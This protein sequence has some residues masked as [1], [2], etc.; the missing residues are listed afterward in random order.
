MRIFRRESSEQGAV[1]VFLIMIFA[2]VF[3]F[4]AVF[5]DF[6]RMSA[7]HAQAESLSRAAVRS[8]LSAYDPI[9]LEQYGL[10]AYGTT[11]ENYIMSKVLQERLSLLP[12]SDDLPIMSTALDSSTVEMLRP[13]GQYSIFNQQIREQMKYKAPIDFSLEIMNQF[14]PISQMMKEASNTMDVM[15]KLQPLYEERERTLD[16][17]LANQKEAAS[18]AEIFP[19]LIKGT[20]TSE[21]INDE[22]LGGEVA[23]A[24]DVAAQYQDYVF[25]LAED[26]ERVANKEK[27]IYSTEIRNY[28]NEA[29]D[30]LLGIA[31][32]NNEVA[33][34]HRDLLPEAS[35]LVAEA[36]Q[37][38]EQMKRVIEDS[39]N[40]V[41]GEVYNLNGSENSTENSQKIQKIRKQSRSLLLPDGL[42]EQFEE[43]VHQQERDFNQL[44][45]AVSGLSIVQSYI[46]AASG[47]DTNS[48]K[49]KITAAN[50]EVNVYLNKYVWSGNNVLA[51]QQKKLDAYRTYDEERKN[52]EKE[53]KGKLSEV[54]S[55]LTKI[56]KLKEKLSANQEQF[57]IL[58]GYYNDNVKFNEQSSEE[59]KRT[60]HMKN[61]PYEAGQGSMKEM[62]DLYGELSQIM[63]SLS[64]ACY[65]TEYGINYYKHFEMG[66]LKNLLTGGGP[67]FDTVSDQ[68]TVANQEVEYLLYGFH[69]TVGNIA[70]AYGEIFAMRLAIRTMEGFVENANKGHPLLILA[71]ALL[72]GVTKALV[73]M[74]DLITK[75][76]LEFSKYVK[77]RLSYRDHLRVFLLVHGTS[78]HRLSRMLALI[79][80][81]T[82]INVEERQ[83]YISGE[84]TLTIPL[85]FLPGLARAS[86]SL[87]SW[88]GRVEGSRYYAIKRA[89][90]SY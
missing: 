50:M 40:R 61:N 3:T 11:D 56:N 74:G 85:W 18:N 43:G 76:D 87:G 6:A 49:S 73:D 80:M 62:D 71:A 53:A 54:S 60:D 83:T 75:G 10:F 77:V 38:N 66:T 90:Y 1:T 4:V 26:T 27:A 31:S 48:I 28:R 20:H 25:K 67:E 22:L 2:A 33:Q 57:S 68:F 89:D 30:L 37:I 45:N 19:K 65:Q 36:H 21:F 5:I 9:L 82:G 7:L 39:E 70:A 17:L 13:L 16:A 51:T 55:M 14:K 72:Y 32:Q 15:S 78:N 69:N 81:N 24:A 58:E 29:N 44:Y 52:I 34:V 47:G 41:I 42:L 23:S 86:N 12:R 59:A 79:R 63:V 84:V 35:T 8:V 88:E 64:D 46:G